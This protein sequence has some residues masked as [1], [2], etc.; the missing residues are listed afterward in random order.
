MMKNSAPR[1]RLLALIASIALLSAC[2]GGGDE[3]EELVLPVPTVDETAEPE[4]PTAEAELERVFRSYWAAIVEME[5]ESEIPAPSMLDGIATDDVKELEFNRIGNLKESGHVREGGVDVG[6]VTV[7]LEGENEALV[8]ACVDS[9][10]WDLFREGEK[11]ELGNQGIGPSVVRAENA[12]EGWLIAQVRL[13]D[14]VT[15]SC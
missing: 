9:T 8:Q 12:S 14:E 11:V 15:I 6:E 4:E 3:S 10:N 5:G 13:F 7:T 1:F 2:S